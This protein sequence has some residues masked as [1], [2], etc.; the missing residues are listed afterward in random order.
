MRKWFYLSLTILLLLTG[1][2]D[3]Q[4]K[5]KDEPVATEKES[6][7]S[8][9]V[10][11]IEGKTFTKNEMEFYALMQKI[12]IERNRSEDVKNSNEIEKTNNYW[13][14]QAAQYDNVNVQ[15][16]SLI[17]VHAMALLAKEKNYF[18]PPEE[19]E[20]AVEDIHEQISTNPDIKKLVSDFGENQF[21]IEIFPYMQEYLLKQRVMAEVEK[22][23]RSTHDGASEQEISYESNAMYDDLYEDQVSGMELKFYIK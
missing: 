17:E 21:D 7:D 2:S 20:E 18:V 4:Q 3:D 14:S 15:L 11:E 13:D 9:K 6:V 8:D 23:V 16:Q 19:T 1:C 12:F 22:D 10:I 5:K